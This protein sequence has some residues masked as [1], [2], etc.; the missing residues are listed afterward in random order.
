M[1]ATAAKVPNTLERPPRIG[2]EIAKVASS[3]V[4]VRWSA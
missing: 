4:K 1:K 2:Q 3:T